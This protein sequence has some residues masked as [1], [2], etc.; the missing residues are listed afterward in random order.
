MAMRAEFITAKRVQ[1]LREYLAGLVGLKCRKTSFS[2]G[3]ELCLHFGDLVPYKSA[4]MKGKKKGTWILCTVGSEWSLF[5]E[6]VAVPSHRRGNRDPEDRLAILKNAIVTAVVPDS[7]AQWLSV[8][9]G[10]TLFAVRPD[11][12]EPDS[13]L[14]SWE[15]FMPDGRLLVA[16]PGSKWSEKSAVAASD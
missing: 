14:P 15:L 7:T 11:D 2:Y 13:E 3:D 6:S 4:K 8:W 10:Q 9:F 12:D 1:K 16:G 5:S